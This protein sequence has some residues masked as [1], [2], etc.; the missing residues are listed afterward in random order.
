MLKYVATSPADDSREQ[1]SVPLPSRNTR[2]D[3]RLREEG[4]PGLHY[5]SNR[6]PRDSFRVIRYYGIDPPA[7]VVPG[8]EDVCRVEPPMRPL[9]AVGTFQARQ[10]PCEGVWRHVHQHCTIGIDEQMVRRI[11][12]T[13]RRAFRPSAEDAAKHNLHRR[14]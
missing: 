7:T 5:G 3:G 10:G 6:Y 4:R 9:R 13:S 8:G 12:Q 1:K 14:D 11:E 2:G